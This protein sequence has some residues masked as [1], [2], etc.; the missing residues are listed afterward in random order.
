MMIPN[1]AFSS[2]FKTSV[3]LRS[4]GQIRD[5]L[6]QVVDR[7]GFAIELAA[8]SLGIDAYDRV[9]ELQLVCASRSFDSGK[10]IS[11]SG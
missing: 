3:L 2:A 4:A 6:L 10:L 8:S 7:D 11:T 1:D 9:F 5:R